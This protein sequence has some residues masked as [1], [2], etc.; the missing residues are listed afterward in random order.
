MITNVMLKQVKLCKS[1]VTWEPGLFM[2][3]EITKISCTVPFNPL[4]TNGFF[5]MVWYNELWIVHI[6]GCQVITFKR[7]FFYLILMKCSIMLHF[8]WVLT[9]CKCT[10]LGV[11][12]IR[13]AKEDKTWLPC[14]NITKSLV[15]QSY[16]CY[17]GTAQSFDSLPWYGSLKMPSRILYSQSHKCCSLECL[18]KF[19]E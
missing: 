5:L 12:G 10:H 7:R 3:T 9:V 6:Y 1:S 2:L 19:P 18:L 8:I 17:T 11:S 4:Y 14:V 15:E 16:V 13:R